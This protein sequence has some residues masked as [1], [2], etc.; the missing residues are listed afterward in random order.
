MA[1]LKSPASLTKLLLT[2]LRKWIL[3]LIKSVHQENGLSKIRDFIEPW[4]PTEISANLIKEIFQ[5]HVLDN[6]AK[7]AFLQALHF[8]ERSNKLVLGKMIK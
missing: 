5:D 4:L 6:E 7:F 3:A 2:Y 1:P 8:P